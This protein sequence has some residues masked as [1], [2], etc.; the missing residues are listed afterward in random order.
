MSNKHY[1]FSSCWIKGSEKSL[2]SVSSSKN[3]LDSGI[4]EDS[5]GFT[6]PKP[7]TEL[8]S[9]SEGNI[10]VNSHSIELQNL[11]TIE[12]G[13]TPPEWL[14]GGLEKSQSYS[15]DLAEFRSDPCDGAVCELH[16]AETNSM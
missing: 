2:S 11:S 6:P 12:E 3:L 15:A 16:D 8:T 10:Y 4:F 5:T 9:I 14:A 1:F 7:V 13:P